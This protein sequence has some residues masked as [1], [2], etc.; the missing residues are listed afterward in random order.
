MV[1]ISV[2]MSLHGFFFTLYG[3]AALAGF[4]GG[5]VMDVRCFENRILLHKKS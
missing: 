2:G 1:Y 4:F 3:L 5:G